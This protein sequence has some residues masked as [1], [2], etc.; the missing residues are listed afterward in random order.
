MLTDDLALLARDDADLRA[1]FEI[2]LRWA[3]RRRFVISHKKTHLVRVGPKWETFV[4]TGT[5]GVDISWAPLGTRPAAQVHRRL[6]YE[7]SAVYL[8][9]LLHASLSNDQHLERQLGMAYAAIAQLASAVAITTSLRREHLSPRTGS[10]CCRSS[11]T[12]SRPWATSRP[13]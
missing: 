2:V 10:S 12:P 4:A 5:H 7:A 13:G 1:M 11:S 6:K 3:W 8:G 9:Y